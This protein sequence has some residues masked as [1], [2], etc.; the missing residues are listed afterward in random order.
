M[1]VTRGEPF[2]EGP[3]NVTD[4]LA[5]LVEGLSE[6]KQHL[7]VDFARFLAA[8]DE[9]REWRQFGATQLARAY[10]PDEPEYSAADIKPSA[11]QRR[12]EMS[13]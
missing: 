12:P 8:D 6:E 7:L 2:G 5:P 3:M 10:G 4:A 9:R 13:R 1:I 11:R